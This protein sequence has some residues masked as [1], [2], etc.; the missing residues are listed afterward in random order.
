M[1]SE[2]S[3]DG[4]TGSESLRPMEWYISTASLDTVLDRRPSTAAAAQTAS[5]GQASQ[6]NDRVNRVLNY[7]RWQIYF[8]TFIGLMSLPRSAFEQ[9]ILTNF[10]NLWCKKV[11]LVGV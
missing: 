7:P 1:V 8:F 3:A 11:L 10:L 2:W 6:Q 5:S 9:F 4:A